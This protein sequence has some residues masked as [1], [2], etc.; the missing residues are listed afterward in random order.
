MNKTCD[1]REDIF[2]ITNS[3]TTT[4]LNDLVLRTQLG[5]SYFKFKIRLIRLGFPFQKQKFL[6]SNSQPTD[7]QSRVLTITPKSQLWVGDNEKLSVTISHAW[8][9]LIEFG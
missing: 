8:L 1:G 7:S 5:F 6:Y 9:I 2:K 4:C 3:S